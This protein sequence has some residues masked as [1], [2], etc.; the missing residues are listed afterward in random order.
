MTQQNQVIVDGSGTPV[1]FNTLWVLDTANDA[2]GLRYRRRFTLSLPTSG[3]AEDLLIDD[4]TGLRVRA[5]HLTFNAIDDD[6]PE[7]AQRTAR[8]NGLLVQLPIP[9]LISSIRFANNVSPGGKTTQLFRTDGDV[10]SEEAVESH[11]NRPPRRV[12]GST[13]KKGSLISDQI[14]VEADNGQMSGPISDH[15]QLQAKIIGVDENALPPGELGV[16]DARILVRLADGG[17]FESLNTD[18]MTEFNLTTGPENLRLSL[19]LPA[20]GDDAFPLPTQFPLDRWIDAGSALKDQLTTLLGRLKDKLATDNP[21]ASTP[22]ILPDP[23][24]V[25]LDVESDAPCR[26]SIDDF[27]VHYHLARE[28]FPDGEPKQVLRFQGDAVSQQQISLNLPSPVTIR[29]A[30]LRLSGGDIN[31]Q[32]GGAG[33]PTAIPIGDLLA[34]P[35]DTGLRIDDQHLWSS[36]LALTEPMLVRGLDLLLNALQAD[37]QLHLEIVADNAG[38]P[39]GEKLASAD[40]T[41]TSPGSA[42]LVR[43]VF[44]EHIL[45]QP[46]TYWL[47]LQ[48][49]A[50]ATVWYLKDQAG[51]KTIQG[52]GDG[53]GGAVDGQAGIAQW[54]AADGPAAASQQMPDLRL[55]DQS[56]GYS[57]DD[58]DLVYDLAPAMGVGGGAGITLLP[59]TLDVLASGPKPLT[60][61]PPRFEFDILS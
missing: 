32:P 42:Q 20:L 30:E 4:A 60:L 25:E 55:N 6:A 51:L 56:L 38:A 14:Q 5:R 9:R 7:S 19:R 37:T 35:G 58:K 46:G 16:T 13:G 29:H 43:F 59:Q 31:A 1:N 54:L 17:A 36:P 49:R 8:D 23:L 11:Y 33:D 22:P 44:G 40:A 3:F 15:G 48:S 45:L 18:S 12:G 28:S 57:I 47:V 61:Y 21:N 53:E 24:L 27:A 34:A 26:F 2:D 52:R 39:Q 10:V 50:G 41:P